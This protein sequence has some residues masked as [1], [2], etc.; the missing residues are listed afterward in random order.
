MAVGMRK[1]TEVVS[2]CEVGGRQVVSTD[3][4]ESL[5]LCS[6]KHG[7]V[8][9]VYSSLNRSRWVWTVTKPLHCQPVQTAFKK[10]T[11]NGDPL[12]AKNLTWHPCSISSCVKILKFY[13][14]NE[15]LKVGL[16]HKVSRGRRFDEVGRRGPLITPLQIA[17]FIPVHRAHAWKSG[18]R[19]Y[20]PFLLKRFILILI[21]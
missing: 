11:N 16:A 19:F 6:C 10:W 15:W 18:T 5:I 7:R 20:P 21:L 9:C 12:R 4:G 3:P 17:L 8:R 14:E 2:S 13:S 1:Q